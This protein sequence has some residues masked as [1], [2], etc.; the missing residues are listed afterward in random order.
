MSSRTFRLARLLLSSLE[1]RI[2][3]LSKKYPSVPEE[4]IRS[5][6]QLD[7]TH[8]SLLE[9]L[10]RQVK[11]G[12]FR[13][14]EDSFRMSP[15]LSTFLQLKKSPRLLQQHSASPDINK[16]T[17]H[18]LE[19][20]HDK[21]S[22]TSLKTQRQ[23]IE[24]SKSK[25][26]KT[27]Y[28]TPTCKIIQIG[29]PNT[30]LEAATQAA[31]TYAKGTKWCT[32]DPDT[33]KGYLSENPLYVIFKNGEKIAQTDGHQVMDIRD[34]DI[35]IDRAPNLWKILS[36]LGIIPPAMY[37]CSYAIFVLKGRF[38]EGEPAIAKDPKFAYFYA[39]HVLHAPFPLG[40]PIISQSLQYTYAYAFNVLKGPFPL[41]ELLISQSAE[42]SYFYARDVIKAPF[43]KGEP[44]I[45]QSPRYSCDYAHYVINGPWPPGESA[46]SQ[47]S[48]YS[49]KYAKRVLEAPFPMGEPII[50]QDPGF[51]VFYAQEVLK[52]P[53]PMGEPI[54]AEIPTYKRDYLRY[55][56][57]REPFL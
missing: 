53:F 27:I 8:G 39:L 10:T 43:P 47:S 56:P 20:L 15:A 11:S 54:I 23:T 25:G 21:I 35:S 18:S 16:Y 46:I 12:Q 45:S 49:A 31:C 7:P 57:S 14:P 22:G 37:A 1:D 13:F 5:L 36:K 4:T 50:A 26:A 41:G 34:R 51:S 30:D 44:A 2:S 29:G 19:S 55:F 3:L 38:P 48:Q 42:Y 33:A 6:S 9:W 28:D 52:A 17:F 40:E 24:E 32:S